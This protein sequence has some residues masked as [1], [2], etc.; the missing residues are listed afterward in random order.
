LSPDGVPAWFAL[1][2]SPRHPDGAR[3]ELPAATAHRE[4]GDD[5]VCTADYGDELRVTAL[6]VG[7]RVAPDAPPLWF[8]E[9]R[10]PSGAP[11]AVSL[12]AFTGDDVPA[13]SL[14]DDLGGTSAT[15]ADQVGAVR[16]YPAT[17]EVDQ[18]YVQPQWRRR[19]IGN[20]LLVCAATLSYARGW[21]RFWGDGQRTTLGEQFR[22]ASPWRGLA[23]DL[24]HVSPPMTPDDAGD[25]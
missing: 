5:A 19:R 7:G 8:V 13:G 12:V 1:V 25:A 3:V 17:G 14:R 9:V 16:W 15:S 24:T 2:D 22:N 18:I 6:R 4:V 21:P 11:P 23:A 20:V 10:E